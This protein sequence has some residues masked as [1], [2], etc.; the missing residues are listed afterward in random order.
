MTVRFLHANELP[1]D[2]NGIYQA[3]AILAQQK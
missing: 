1:A 3:S 2:R